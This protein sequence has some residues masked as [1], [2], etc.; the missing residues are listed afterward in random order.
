[1]A[2]IFISY[3]S[4]DRELSNALGEAL[5][6]KKG[7]TIASYDENPDSPTFEEAVAAARAV[8]VV[9]S[10]TST[11]SEWL[12]REARLAAQR[13]VLFPVLIDNAVIPKEFSAIAAFRLEDI[14][15]KGKR[16]RDFKEQEQ[17]ADHVMVLGSSQGFIDLSMKLELHLKMSRPTRRSWMT[18]AAVAVAALI[19][20][21][22]A[23]NRPWRANG[24]GSDGNDP[25]NVSD[26]VGPRRANAQRV[27]V[28]AH[29]VLGTAKTTWTATNG[30]YWPSLLRNDPAFNDDDVFVI[31]YPSPLLAASYSID[32]LA[33]KFRLWLDDKGVFQSHKEVVFICH[34]MGGLAVR[35]F[36][37]KNQNRNFAAQVPMIY[38]LSTPTTGSSVAH[39]VTPIRS[40]NPQ[41]DGLAKWMNAEYVGTLVSAWDT[42]GF[43]IK[44]YCAYETRDFYGV[45]IV[46]KE[47]AT[48][49]CNQRLDPMDRDHIAIAKPRNE[50]DEPY[51][52][53]KSAYVETFGSAV[54]STRDSEMR[55][56]TNSGGSS[57][58][59][60]VTPKNGPASTRPMWPMTGDSQI[61]FVHTK[62]NELE[63]KSGVREI[64]VRNAIGDMLARPGYSHP[65]EEEPARFLFA[66]Q[67]LQLMLQKYVS[68]FSTRAAEDAIVKLTRA[69]IKLEQ[70]YDGLYGGNLFLHNDLGR[71]YDTEDAFVR[72]LPK[73]LKDYRN[74]TFAD[75][76]VRILDEIRQAATQ[77]GLR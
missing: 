66:L 25:T 36:L 24:S 15:R 35:A 61:D 16:E 43:K 68:V 31:D 63:G 50:S 37:L 76:A 10:P 20:I 45:R 21:S 27:I 53:V 29:G 18:L 34:S 44:S 5:Q 57:S 47:S 49:S 56:A 8:I 65:F 9:W 51:I 72:A 22:I 7:W 73:A 28:F 33:D 77:A 69:V 19:G 59:G 3:A 32:E 67:R 39:L 2:D 26:Y 17:A 46:S 60:S 12:L 14:R 70:H 62:L 52:A 4:A 30:A 40:L 41:F 11:D 6:R 71:Q 1:M 13:S 64:D 38:F 74:Q 23:I 42:A 75:A 58:T 48:H 55:P 54:V